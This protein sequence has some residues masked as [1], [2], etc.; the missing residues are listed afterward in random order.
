MP[1]VYLTASIVSDEGLAVSRRRKLGCGDREEQALRVAAGSRLSKF[2][3]A[4]PIGRLAKGQAS[5]RSGDRGVGLERA[6]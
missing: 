1:Q 2:N 3:R 5:R 6:G 4:A